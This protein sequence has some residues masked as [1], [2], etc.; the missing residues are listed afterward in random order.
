MV[1]ARGIVRACGIEIWTHQLIFCLFMLPLL[2]L[3]FPGLLCALG[4]YLVS[5]ALSGP[6]AATVLSQFQCP[7]YVGHVLRTTRRRVRKSH[8]RARRAKRFIAVR[9]GA[10]GTARRCSQDPGARALVESWR[11]GAAAIGTLVLEF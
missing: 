9:A 11:G 4:I 8:L 7:A 1:D 6:V 2:L 5:F 10:D 3:F